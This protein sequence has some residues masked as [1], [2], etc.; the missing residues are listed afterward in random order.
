VDVIAKGIVEAYQQMDI[1][2]PVVIRLAGTN[3]EEGQ[4]ILAE[5]GISFIRA[6]DF[7]DGACKV[8]QAAKG[9]V[10]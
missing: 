2:F 1:P 5:S 4:R 9:V 6:K 7:Y 8:V 10:K 3:L